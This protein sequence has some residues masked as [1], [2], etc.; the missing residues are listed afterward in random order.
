VV[1][2]QN[3][4]LPIYYGD[5]RNYG[6]SASASAAAASTV[7]EATA[8]PE[9]AESSASSKKNDD[10]ADFGF[11]SAGAS[12]Y[13]FPAAAY[14]QP[15]PA[16]FTAFGNSN[17]LGSFSSFK[18]AS[19][20]PL[21]FYAFPSS[22]AAALTPDLE[23]SPSALVPEVGAQRS[24]PSSSSP[25]AVEESLSDLVDLRTRGETSGGEQIPN[26]LEE[27]MAHIVQW[28]LSMNTSPSGKN[29]LTI[30]PV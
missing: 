22:A 1:E 18:A 10:N 17:N 8:R 7:N 2:Y 23:P 9:K 19:P 21:P 20:S 12:G 24:G 25:P 4:P 16:P 27:R 26:S 30:I 29:E 11:G 6:K 5:L 28:V 13:Q 14:K 15:S 3:E